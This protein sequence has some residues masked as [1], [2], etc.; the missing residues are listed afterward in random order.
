MLTNAL[1]RSAAMAGCQE[2]LLLWAKPLNSWVSNSFQPVSRLYIRSGPLHGLFIGLPK[3]MQEQVA[4]VDPCY[5]EAFDP[6]NSRP[7]GDESRL[8]VEL[9]SEM[10]ACSSP[11]LVE[12]QQRVHW[13]Q[14][15]EMF[16]ARI[17]ASENHYDVVEWVPGQEFLA[18][19]SSEH[20][21]LHHLLLELL[22]RHWQYYND[23]IHWS[24][25]RYYRARL[26]RGR[27]R[28][29]SR[30]RGQSK[31]Q[32]TAQ[33]LGPLQEE[34]KVDKGGELCAFVG[35]LRHMLV[36]TSLARNEEVCRTYLKT[37]ALEKVLGDSVPYLKCTLNND[38]LIELLGIER[39]ASV[40]ALLKYSNT[41]AR[42]PAQGSCDCACTGTWCTSLRLIRGPALPS[43]QQKSTCSSANVQMRN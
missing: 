30:G 23:K 33:E 36:P 15:K 3:S 29:I 17:G 19:L 20:A 40:P 13:K 39:T 12:K 41:Q 32:N 24:I 5:F 14:G 28:G 21:T 37:Q 9:L 34:T 42:I 4:F 10:G 18:L 38:D 1:G 22:D 7:G 26:G 31:G 43:V 6:D 8:L 11:K 27:G 25:T 35:L 2:K 16:G